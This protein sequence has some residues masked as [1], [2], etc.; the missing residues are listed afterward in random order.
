MRVPRFAVV[1]LLLAPLVAWAGQEPVIT[2]DG[3]DGA[4]QSYPCAPPIDVV[5]SRVVGRAG[6]S[7]R[8]A[9]HRL[10]VPRDAIRGSARLTLREHA[11]SF[12]VVS[13]HPP[14]LAMQREVEIILSTHR[15]GPQTEP[16]AGA[17]RFTPAT[18]WREVPREH[19]TVRPGADSGEFE[20]V[21]LSAGFSSYALIAP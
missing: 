13:L 6:G 18:G 21:I 11:G 9:R 16:P 17:M 2:D 14:G 5:D 7:L 10:V 1:A 20:V 19:L 12:L 4:L 15:C 3:K 8:A